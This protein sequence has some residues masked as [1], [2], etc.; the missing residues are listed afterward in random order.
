V[1]AGRRIGDV[2]GLIDVLPTVLDVLGLPAYPAAQGRS[3]VPLWQGQ[4]LPARTLFAEE[5]RWSNL[6][7][8]I[9]PPRKWIF[10]TDGAPAR[11]FDLLRDP[12]ELQDIAPTLADG[13]DHL[14]DDF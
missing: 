7:A 13:G 12:D 2:V 4:T 3:L 9:T 11:A 6:V 8:A 10:S 14:L 5:D 1:S